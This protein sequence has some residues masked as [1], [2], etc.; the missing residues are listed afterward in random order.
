MSINLQ[1]THEITYAGIFSVFFT[2]MATDA[3]YQYFHS[4]GQSVLSIEIPEDY[5]KWFTHGKGDGQEWI[6][7]TDKTLS[8]ASF[9]SDNNL[10]IKVAA[11]TYQDAKL[12]AI[13]LLEGTIPMG[14]AE[15]D[16]IPVTFWSLSPNGPTSLTRNIEVPEWDDIIK[17]YNVD[18]KVAIEQMIS[19]KP[20]RSGQ[21]FLWHGVPG[22]G[23]T[24]AL[25]A[26]GR[27]WKDWLELHY[28]TDPE[29]FFGDSAYYMM[30]VLITEPDDEDKWRL[31]I[32]EDTGEL[33]SAD[34]K[35]NTGQGLS[36]LLNTVDGMIGQGLRFL[37]LIT[38]N[39]KVD[40]LHPA[41][42]RPG[43]CAANILFKELYPTEIE[44]WAKH[45]EVEYDNTIQQATIADLYDVFHKQITTNTKGAVKVGF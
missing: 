31:F 44:A 3:G 39:E 17:N 22:T 23:K 10:Y 40:K 18:T 28:I 42:A 12:F 7:E 19:L 14:E 5:I 4:V 38:T 34:A 36:R 37:V 27:S 43:R 45:N 8:Y 11:K 26:L 33:I 35:K 32:L 21:L 25:R 24:T 29:T 41:I 30:K 15:E 16:V 2:K 13:K 20:S 1:P 9:S 6:L